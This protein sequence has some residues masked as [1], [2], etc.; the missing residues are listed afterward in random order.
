MIVKSKDEIEAIFEKGREQME[1]GT[2]I[3]VK[4]VSALDLYEVLCREMSFNNMIELYKLIQYKM[5]YLDDKCVDRCEV[6]NYEDIK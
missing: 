1:N 2:L 5:T 6:A 3:A 4:K